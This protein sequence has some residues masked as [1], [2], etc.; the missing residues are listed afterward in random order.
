MCRGMI[1]ISDHGG[2]LRLQRGKEECPGGER[3]MDFKN[4]E[5]YELI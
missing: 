3:G 1:L 5:A 2:D 4:L